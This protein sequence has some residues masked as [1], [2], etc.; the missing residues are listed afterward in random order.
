MGRPKGCCRVDD[1]FLT[2]GEGLARLIGLGLFAGPTRLAAR[3]RCVRRSK[4]PKQDERQ[5]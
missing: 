2:L 5:A 1:V 4:A 3:R